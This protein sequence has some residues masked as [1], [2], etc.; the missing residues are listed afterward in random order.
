MEIVY[1][2]DKPGKDGIKYIIRGP[3]IDWGV[4]TLE[5]NQNMSPH[6]HKEVE[7]TFYIISG[8]FTFLIKDKKELEAPAGTAIR[9]EATESH[10]FKNKGKT[11]AKCV[12]IK[13]IYKPDDKVA[14]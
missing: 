2:K 7:E 8:T 4:I 6:Y 12:F 10:G 1:E 11:P 9:F 13:H 5:P 14:C 3:N